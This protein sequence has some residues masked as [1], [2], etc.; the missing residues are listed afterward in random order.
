[1]GDMVSWQ[2]T[3]AFLMRNTKTYRMTAM[4]ALCAL[5]CGS[6][7]VVAV[8]QE[9]RL[10]TDPLTVDYD[11]DG[12]SNMEENLYGTNP[13]VR[14][15]DGDGYSDGVEVQSGF[16]PRVP[17][18]EGDRVAGIGVRSDGDGNMTAAVDNLTAKVNTLVAGVAVDVVSGKEVKLDDA[19]KSVEEAL[20]GSLGFD[21]LPQIDP[22]SI[23]IKR[24]DYDGMTTAERRAQVAKDV[25][26]YVAAMTY[27][28]SIHAT[29]NMETTDQVDALVDD[30]VARAVNLETDA[31]GIGYFR[32]LAVSGQKMLDEMRDVE[33][34]EVMVALHAEGLQLAVYAAALGAAVTE[35]QVAEDPM[36]LMVAFSK[37]QVLMTQFADFATRANEVLQ[38][39]SAAG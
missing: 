13:D 12:L 20:G 5:T 17:S 33:V 4:L 39:Y 26:D 1:M 37:A 32:K 29:Q 31:S 15:T 21:T 35:E 28:V 8:A 9:R 24:Q 38:S 3:I 14:D 16:D 27:I 10:S 11:Q 25:A 7:A 22:A 34:P 2:H 19:A 36:V 30:A 23:R 18:S 6:V